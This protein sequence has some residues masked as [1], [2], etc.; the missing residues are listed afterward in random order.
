MSNIRF[1]LVATLM[2]SACQRAP[3]APDQPAHEAAAAPSTIVVMPSAAALA[4]AGK[5]YA[6][7][8]QVC[9]GVNGGGN[10]PMSAALS[11]APRSF[12]DSAWQRGASNADIADI[13]VRGGKAV[14]RSASMP[15]APD[16][17]S[18]PEVVAG[19]VATVRGFEA[20]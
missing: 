14:G 9:H 18:Q 11:P 12:V 2:A 16:L 8:C 13:I 4:Q 17:A 20:K 3:T 7:R 5:L 6:A 19:L 15:A 1:A 10:G